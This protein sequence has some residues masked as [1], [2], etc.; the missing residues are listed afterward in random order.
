MPGPSNCGPWKSC[1]RPPEEEPT[2]R[3]SSFCT[4]EDLPVNRFLRLPI[5]CAALFGVA[6]WFERP[7]PAQFPGPVRPLRPG[8]GYKP[9]WGHEPIRPFPE[10][11]PGMPGTE[12]QRYFGRPEGLPRE[13]FPGSGFPGH[14]PE[15]FVPE[16]VVPD[17][18][19]Q[20]ARQAQLRQQALDTVQEQLLRSPREALDTLAA[21]QD[22]LHQE[23]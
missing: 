20:R 22:H 18:T 12:F 11:L 5:F 1:S 2:E 13:L 16:I 17:Y 3:E 8:P 9:G 15:V 10:R 4:T 7:A 23:D 21:H 19:A 14:E 6:L